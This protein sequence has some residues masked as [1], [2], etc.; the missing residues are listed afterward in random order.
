MATM[1]GKPFMIWEFMIINPIT[2]WYT[3][4][5]IVNGLLT[6]DFKMVIFHGYIGLPEGS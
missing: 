6:V 2:L 1:V 3:N 4:T 5:A